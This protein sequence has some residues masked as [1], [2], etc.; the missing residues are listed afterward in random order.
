[1][2]ANLGKL[3]LKGFYFAS[4]APGLLIRGLSIS[5]ILVSLVLS[6]SCLAVDVLDFVD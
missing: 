3:P 1:M 5:A 2:L 6:N 4:F